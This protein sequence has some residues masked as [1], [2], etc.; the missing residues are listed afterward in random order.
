MADKRRGYFSPEK[1]WME[2]TLAWASF[3]NSYSLDF[4]NCI[5]SNE[6]VKVGY[7]N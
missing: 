1:F 6:S 5:Y 2:E 4:M 7:T 3:N